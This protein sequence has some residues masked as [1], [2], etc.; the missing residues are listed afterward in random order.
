MIPARPARDSD[1]VGIDRNLEEPLKM[2]RP[3]SVGFAST[4]ALIAKMS[5]SPPRWT[6]SRYRGLS[7]A[8]M[9]PVGSVRAA[10]RIAGLSKLS[11]SA[12][13][14]FASSPNS[15]DFPDCLGPLTITTR[16]IDRYSKSSENADLARIST[17]KDYKKTGAKSIKRQVSTVQKDRPR[18]EERSAL[19]KCSGPFLD[20][21]A[22]D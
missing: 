12:L 15:V 20:Q 3:R 16:K 4:S 7:A 17:R 1:N 5:W 8:A 10:R 6:S 11:T 13:W 14:A 18:S 2:N 9:K 21:V 22:L 19:P